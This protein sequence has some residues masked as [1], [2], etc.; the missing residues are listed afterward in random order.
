MSG[1]S[2]EDF[3]SGKTNTLL[4][5]DVDPAETGL[6]DNYTQAM[7][8]KQEGRLVEAAQL[9]EKSCRPAS[10]YKGHYRALFV[11]WRQFNK[12]DMSAKRHKAVVRRV[13][14]MIKYDDQMIAKMLKQ[15]S[16]VQKRQLP[17]DYFY[18]DR[19]LKVTDAKT[20]LKAAT[21][22]GDAEAV[23]VAEKALARF[24]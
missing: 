12:H 15:W 10:I 5:R 13:L 14:K 20:L 1:M 2:V 9:L 17:E 23:Q 8:L 24:G 18:R 11:I 3:L 19:N 21:A 4:A 6:F 7:A 16:K 22:A